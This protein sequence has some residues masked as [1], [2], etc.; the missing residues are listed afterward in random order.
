ML[1][2][3]SIITTSL[4]MLWVAGRYCWLTYT[5]QTDPVFAGW[6]VLAV[7]VSMAFWTYCKTPGKNLLDNIGNINKADMF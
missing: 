4:L 5:G 2:I 1:R 6:L 7:S 3:I